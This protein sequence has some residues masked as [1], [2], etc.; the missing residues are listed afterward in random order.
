M[1]FEIPSIQ[2]WINKSSIGKGESHQGGEEDDTVVMQIEKMSVE[3]DG[4][5][6]SM[7]DEEKA[8]STSSLPMAITLSQMM[9][10]FIMTTQR[11]KR[12]VTSARP[13]SSKMV[14][15]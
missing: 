5:M 7:W 13:R 6:Q 11:D 9:K 12:S 15:V 8:S 4:L 10:S 3:A 2:N 14:M 1:S